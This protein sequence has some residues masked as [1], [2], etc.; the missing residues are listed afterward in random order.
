[1]LRTGTGLKIRAGIAVCVVLLTASIAFAAIKETPLTG[2]WLLTETKSTANGT[3]NSHPQPGYYMFTGNHYSRMGVTSDGPRPDLPRKVDE[4]TV[5]VSQ[6]LAVWG[7]FFAHGGTYTI[8]GDTVRIQVDI[9]SGPRVM[10][11]HE[12]IV[13]K[14][15]I[16]GD[17]LTMTPL[18]DA[19]GPV[20]KPQIITLTRVE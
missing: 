9:S 20:T 19:N 12:F 17:K 14:F 11:N 13:Y 6:L 16:E 15:R 1:M 18:E 10:N 8:S 4:T 7:K 3:T 5:T 2:T